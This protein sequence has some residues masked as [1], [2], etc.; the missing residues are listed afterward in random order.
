MEKFL[1]KSTKSKSV[2]SAKS[3]SENQA[4]SEATIPKNLSTNTTGIIHEEL[5]D[6]GTK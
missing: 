6:C 1:I 4:S 5:I 2:K 3:D